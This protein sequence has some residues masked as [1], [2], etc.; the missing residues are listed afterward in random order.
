MKTDI[1]KCEVC[2]KE[3]NVYFTTPQPHID[4]KEGV[5]IRWT[6]YKWICN[7]CWAEI[8]KEVKIRHGF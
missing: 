1:R 4:S 2:K 5:V 8:M 3:I 7:E 6:N